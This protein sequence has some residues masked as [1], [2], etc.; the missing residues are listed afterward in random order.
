MRKMKKIPI[1]QQWLDDLKKLEDIRDRLQDNTDRLY[2]E[3]NGGASGEVVQSAEAWS[4]IKNRAQKISFLLGDLETYNRI[5]DDPDS[6]DFLKE[7]WEKIVERSKPELERQIKLAFRRQ[8]IID[9]AFALKIE[10][11]PKTEKQIEKEEEVKEEVKKEKKVQKEIEK[12]AKVITK[13]TDKAIQTFSKAV[14]EIQEDLLEEIE[15]QIKRLDLKGDKIAVTVKNLSTLNSIK[16]KLDK[17]I[18]SKGY[19]EEVKAFAKTFNEV[20]QMQ[21]D[22]WKTAEAKFKPRPLLKA[23]RNQAITDTVQSLTSSGIGPNVSDQIVGILRQNITAGGS[24]ADLA[25]QLRES[26]LTTPES[27]GLLERYT[28][29]VTSDSINQFNRQYTQV[30]SSDLGYEWYRYMNTDIT[31]TRCFCD[32]MTD[33]DFFHITEVPKLLRGQGLTCKGDPVK[34]YPKTELP[35]GMIPGTNAENFFIRAGGYN[36][37]HSIQPVA[38][39]QVPAPIRALIEATPE[40]IAYA[41]ARQ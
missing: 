38:A 19:M 14:P 22:L 5:L 2:R 31:T 29:Q 12:K 11:A 36:C 33:K 21:A 26:I 37:R 27:P 1:S 20:F 30:V 41:N 35:Y 25:G 28:K 3:N 23:I 7:K 4:D 32:A 40:Y 34:I 6:P 39:R 9:A 17:L 13:K 16:K 15:L 10:Q 8:K 18:L 24:Y